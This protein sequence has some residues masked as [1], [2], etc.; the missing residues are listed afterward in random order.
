MFRL[1]PRDFAAPEM[2]R[3]RRRKTRRDV[4]FRPTWNAPAETLEVRIV[5]TTT[6]V[7]TGAGLTSNFSDQNNWQSHTIPQS[8]DNLDFPL[9]SENATPYDD[10]DG[11]GF[12]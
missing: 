5:P 4:R 2:P 7:W 3:S 6:D 12:G 11:V 8:G 1:F 9:G 10:M